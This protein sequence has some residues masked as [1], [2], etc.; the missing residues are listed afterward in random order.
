MFL[1]DT[2]RY[3]LRLPA[4]SLVPLFK[5]ATSVGR[6]TFKVLFTMGVHDLI[7]PR[8]ASYL[9]SRRRRTRARWTRAR[10]TQLPH[11]GFPRGSPHMMRSFCYPQ[12]VRYIIGKGANP[13]YLIC[14][15]HRHKRTH[16]ENIAPIRSYD[17][18]R[19]VVEHYKEEGYGSIDLCRN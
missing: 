19:L 8:I 14:L 13:S 6:C 5:A 1:K 7:C 16:H 9:A 15:Y 3:R 4:V 17:V 2:S 11:H 18:I 10:W 12:N